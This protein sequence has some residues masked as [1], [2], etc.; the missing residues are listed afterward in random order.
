MA[1]IPP[2]S[3]KYEYMQEGQTL[4]GLLGPNPDLSQTRL[5]REQGLYLFVTRLNINNGGNL[6]AL[7]P[8]EE[9][10]TVTATVITNILPIGAAVLVA[11]TVLSYLVSKVLT[12]PIHDMTGQIRRMERH[13]DLTQ[14]IEPAAIVEIDTIATSLTDFL[15]KNRHTLTELS[16]HSSDILNA[17]DRVGHIIKTNEQ[18]LLSQQKQLEFLSS[19]ILE[20]SESVKQVAQNAQYNASEVRS[21]SALVLEGKGIISSTVQEIH[22]LEKGLAEANARVNA[23]NQSTRDI[24]HVLE[25]IGGIA[26]QT[27]LLAL[28]AAIEAARAGEQGRGFAVVADEV[29]ALASKTK[30]STGEVNQIISKLQQAA[31]ESVELMHQEVKRAEDSARHVEQANEVLSRIQSAINN[32][33][34]LSQQTA[35]STDEQATVSA[36][37]AHAVHDLS[38]LTDAAVDHMGQT[39]QAV[40]AVA[41]H[42]SD[43]QKSIGQFRL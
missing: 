26:E 36:S 13:L 22:M 9:L 21:S 7:F 14:R 42:I 43:V 4:E 17:S 25:V 12:K 1:A 29:R 31:Q 5:M 27:N 30:D 15:V 10:R 41:Q 35:T 39:R 23:L 40:T 20:M 6:V 11:C 37:L 28:N 24:E 19:S 3:V 34:A 32:I 16:R 8:A 18:D 33:E 2:A 38:G